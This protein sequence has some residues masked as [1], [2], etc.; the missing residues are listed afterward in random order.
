MINFVNLFK[1]LAFCMAPV[2]CG[3]ALA[4]E[5]DGS[6]EAALYDAVISNLGIYLFVMV[7]CLVIYNCIYKKFPESSLYSALRSQAHDCFLTLMLHQTL[8]PNQSEKT[9][10][11]QPG[12]HAQILMQFGSYR[13]NSG[14]F[15]Y[16]RFC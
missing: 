7:C 3:N 14:K 5:P 2:I 15:S 10:R 4:A 13:V 9:N 11:I 16:C 6:S 12:K 1:Y 8:D